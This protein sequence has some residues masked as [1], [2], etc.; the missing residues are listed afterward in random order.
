MD[1]D[2]PSINSGNYEDAWVSSYDRA[3]SLLLAAKRRREHGEDHPLSSRQPDR[4]AS[5]KVGST[6]HL[7]SNLLSRL[8][9]MFHTH[10]PYGKEGARLINKPSVNLRSDE[11]HEKKAVTNR[12][13]KTAHI[14]EWDKG[15]NEFWSDTV[16]TSGDYIDSRVTA[17]GP[18]VKTRLAE[19]TEKKR[20]NIAV[21][22]NVSESHNKSLG[23]EKYKRY[24]RRKDR[25]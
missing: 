4:D 1:Y 9:V 17:E 6:S 12:L 15:K 25:G 21:N 23:T 22:K 10:T 19:S 8:S 20:R 14:R 2:F 24:R 7:S 18:P 13:S 5:T 16:A 3:K 11:T